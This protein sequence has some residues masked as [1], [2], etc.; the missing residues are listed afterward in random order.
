MYSKYV[1]DCLWIYFSSELGTASQERAGAQSWNIFEFLACAG[2]GT[3]L[4]S[5]LGFSC[6][7]SSV[8]IPGTKD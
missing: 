2:I 7:N 6:A 3:E 1:R 5:S 4:K 8:T